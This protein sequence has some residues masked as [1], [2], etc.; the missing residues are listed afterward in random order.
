MLIFGFVNRIL[1]VWCY[2]SLKLS[3]SACI[4]KSQTCEKRGRYIQEK[5]ELFCW[6]RFFHVGLSTYFVEA[7]IHSRLVRSRLSSISRCDLKSL[8]RF[9]SF[10]CSLFSSMREVGR[11][12]KTFTKVVDSRSNQVWRVESELLETKQKPVRLDESRR[13]R[14]IRHLHTPYLI[15]PQTFA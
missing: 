10:P 11:L 13:N 12:L 5:V 3:H 14:A 9:L 7:G 4:A 6:W 1:H 8:F 15:C 2:H